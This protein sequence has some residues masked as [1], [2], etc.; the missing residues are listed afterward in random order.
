[1]LNDV[2]LLD[3]KAKISS[4]H[5]IMVRWVRVLDMLVVDKQ[6]TNVA[7]K[8]YILREASMLGEPL[9]GSAFKTG[10]VASCTHL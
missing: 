7:S 9:I 1:M 3:T 4:I 10:N 6:Y 8:G 5:D 2:Y